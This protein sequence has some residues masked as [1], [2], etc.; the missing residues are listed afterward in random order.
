MRVPTGRTRAWIT[1]VL[2]AGPLAAGIPA[3]AATTLTAAGGAL[4]TV[5]E[6][7]P[8][9]AQSDPA[10][11]G[12]SIA[13]SISD[14]AGTRSGTIRSTEDPAADLS[15]QLALDPATGAVVAVWSHFDGVAFRIAYARLQDG[16]FTDV[17]P[18]TFGRSDDRLPRVGTAR[19]GSYLFWVA[20]DLRYMYA[21]IDLAAGRLF[22]APK[23]LPLGLL[24]KD[25]LSLDRVAEPAGD[26][27]GSRPGGRAG[28]LL[29]PPTGTGQELQDTPVFTGNNNGTKGGGG[30]KAATWGAA[31][32]PDCAHVV[33]V[34]PERN[35]RYAW[36]VK[37]TDGALEAIRSI[38]LPDPP[39]D[40]FGEA[41][42]SAYLA[43]VC[44]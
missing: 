34:V 44:R 5:W 21:P 18:L 29:T 41:T 17:H 22:A 23:T 36:V 6:D 10:S 16:D 26:A 39:P 35:L 43:L 42:A 31:G 19:S 1:A 32:D 4:I 9:A 7:H 40:R 37:F 28:R 11:A 27:D 8:A 38:A 2:A 3:R 33:L 13:Y 20:N 24:R 30:T 14:A 12:S 15:P 25:A